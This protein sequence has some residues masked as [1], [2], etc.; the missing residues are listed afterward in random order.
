M[1]HLSDVCCVRLKA[2]KKIC[3]KNSD[4]SGIRLL[5]I[6]LLRNPQSSYANDGGL[7]IKMGAHHI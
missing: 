3:K 6:V 5:H 7:P 2:E 4:F 1:F